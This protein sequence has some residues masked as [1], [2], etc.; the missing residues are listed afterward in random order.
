MQP[1]LGKQA[2]V[3]YY[4]PPEVDYRLSLLPENCKGL[5]LWVLEAKVMISCIFWFLMSVHVWETCFRI[6]HGTEAQDSRDGCDEALFDRKFNR[7]R[8]CR[9]LLRNETYVGYYSSCFMCRLGHRVGRC[10][11]SQNCSTLHCS[12]P[13]DPMWKSLQNA[14]HGKELF[15]HLT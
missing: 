5:I 11:R 1:H 3:R 14:A 9:E 7:R 4:Y 10:C 6:I 12:Q 13:F 15:K 2:L 8:W